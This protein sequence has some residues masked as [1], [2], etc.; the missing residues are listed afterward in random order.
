MQIS[1]FDVVFGNWYAC[2]LHGY[3][4]KLSHFVSVDKR[5]DTL[6]SAVLFHASI[7]IQPASYAHT[8]GMRSAAS[9]H[10]AGTLEES[11]LSSDLVSS[12]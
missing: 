7:Q 8:F 6:A 1:G 10:T 3:V 2:V 12:A 5:T 4:N 9:T 11:M